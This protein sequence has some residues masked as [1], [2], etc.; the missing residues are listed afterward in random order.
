LPTRV[1]G[2]RLNGEARLSSAVMTKLV[3]PI[4]PVARAD[5]A[6][7]VQWVNVA[8]GIGIIL[9][10][11]A[12]VGRGVLK[13]GQGPRLYWVADNAIYAFHMPLFF[14]LSGLFVARGAQRSAGNFFG[15]KLRTIV[16]PYFLWAAL[17]CLCVALAGQNAKDGVRVS[18]WH[19]I[20]R[21]PWEPY[22]GSQ[23]W[24]L[25]VLMAC[26]TLFWVLYQLR[27]GTAGIAILAAAAYF[28]GGR[29]HLS[30]LGGAFDWLSRWSVLYQVRTHFLT[31]AMGALLAPVILRPRRGLPIGA[32]ALVGT[33]LV[34]AEVWLA[35]RYLDERMPTTLAQLGAF[36]TR[37]GLDA[38]DWLAIFP[39][40]MG[41]AGTC[42]IAGALDRVDRRFVGPTLEW[43]GAL[44]LPIFVA[45]VIVAAAVRVALLRGAHV[46]NLGVHL[47]LGTLFGLAVPVILDAAARRAGFNYLFSFGTTKSERRKAPTTS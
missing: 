33:A 8:K 23:F 39:M 19:V 42:L 35:T 40:A 46:Q 29:V 18:P 20:T 34:V 13:P 25:Y 1:F 5:A 4:A 37:H 9:M 3:D 2:V 10:V 30:P 16:Y 15:S 43:L 27:I 44:T 11:F 14:F 45:Q 7:R 36:A 21:L 38:R 31:F 41:V 24:F 12:H 22:V 17:Q 6:A 26:M 28:G 32:L 47:L